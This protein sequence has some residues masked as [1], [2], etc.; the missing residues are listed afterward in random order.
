MQII[1]FFKS[2]MMSVLSAPKRRMSVNNVTEFLYSSAAAWTIDL[3]S[4]ARETFTERF[5]EL[6]PKINLP[7]MSVWSVAITSLHQSS[8]VLSTFCLFQGAVRQN[9]QEKF[10]SV[11]SAVKISLCGSSLSKCCH[12][13]KPSFYHSTFILCYFSRCCSLLTMLHPLVLQALE[14][15]TTWASCCLFWG[16]WAIFVL[17]FFSI[18]VGSTAAVSWQNPE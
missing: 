18:S 4:R 13:H 6:K 16:T 11:C 9:K 2:S 7:K 8:Y 14:C 17:Y 1:I 5:L 15:R 12:L 3:S 10:T